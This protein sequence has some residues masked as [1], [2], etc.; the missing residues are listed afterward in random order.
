MKSPELHQQLNYEDYI[1]GTRTL[2]DQ[3]Q[4][5]DRPYTTKVLGQSFIVLPNVF[6]PKYFND[7]S[8]FSQHL[9]IRSGEVMLE[10]GP[11][12]GV[13]SINAILKGASKVVAVDI[14]PSAV[15]NTKLNVNQFGLENKID[16]RQG[17]LYTPLKPG[18][19]FDTIFWNTPFGYIEED[20]I[21]DI[22]KSVFDPY[23][24]STT[25]FITEAKHHLKDGGRL[26]IGFS[27]TLG[28]FE[29]LEQI[30]RDAGF[31]LHLVYEEESSEVHSV[32]FEIYE[33]SNQL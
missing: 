9:P 20:N 2:L 10:I 16:V 28:K 32:K 14:N 12:T 29:Y 11:G 18:E 31:D 23:Y 19:K 21:S 30:V 5:E 6:S 7:T 33:A 22:K 1:K 15:A 13:I 27:S 8:I 3:S 25:K 17:D 24:K 4:Q 26:L